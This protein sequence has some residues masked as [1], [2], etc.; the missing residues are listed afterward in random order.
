MTFLAAV[1]NPLDIITA[2]DASIRFPEILDACREK[3]SEDI[4]RFKS[5]VAESASSAELLAKIRSNRFSADERMSLLKMFRRSVSPVIDTEMAKKITKVSTESIVG[6]LGHTFKSIQLL[7][8][9][10]AAITSDQEAALAA[11]IGEYDTRGQL[12]YMLTGQF[13]DWFESKFQ[14]QFSIEGPRGAGRDIELS[15]VLEGY[16]GNYPCD[17]VIRQ[18][19]SNTVVAVGFARYDS[20]RGGAQS[21]DRT[22]GNSDKVG[23]AKEFCAA[24]GKSLRLVFLAD[25]PGLAHRDTWEEA[26]K[27]DN[28]WN[29]NVRVVTLKTAETQISPDWLIQS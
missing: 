28:S 27:L 14:R 22:G 24:T 16:R 25:G 26:C 21:D 8:R 13:F 19:P 15:T 17:F 3:Y 9:Q 7:K 11:L 6:T 20:T 5:L 4:Q 10:F 2:I 1:A 29:G 12:G 18:L 23:K